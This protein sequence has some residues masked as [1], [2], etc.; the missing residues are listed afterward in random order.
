MS[1]SV[2]PHI[3]RS[4]AVHRIRLAVLIRHLYKHVFETQTFLFSSS[5]I[6]EAITPQRSAIMA[7]VA[8]VPF[9]YKK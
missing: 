5:L 1:M 6:S 2:D 3:N 4:I 7:T 8:N 9:I